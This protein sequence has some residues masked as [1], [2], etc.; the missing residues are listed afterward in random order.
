MGSHSCPN[1]HMGGRRE[2]LLDCGVEP[3]K[4]C[5]EP[6]STSAADQG[7][8]MPYQVVTGWLECVGPAHVK[9]AG[10]E[11]L[12][13]TDV[14]EAF[15]LQGRESHGSSTVRVPLD[16]LHDPNS[17]PCSPQSRDQS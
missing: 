6:H 5:F 1:S 2:T 10:A 15:C 17:S 7:A 12:Q 8:C 16:A 11:R 3:T 14:V 9:G 13:H 4:R